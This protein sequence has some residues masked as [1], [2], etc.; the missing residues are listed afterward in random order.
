LFVDA[1]RQLVVA[2]LS[3]D[4]LPVDAARITATLRAVSAIRRVLAG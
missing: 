1:E 2:K 4:E 3:S